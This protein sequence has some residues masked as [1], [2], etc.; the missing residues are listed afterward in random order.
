VARDR[1]AHASPVTV[2]T[3]A[4]PGTY[5][6]ECGKPATVVAVKTSDTESGIY[7][8]GRCK[9]HAHAP[10]HDNAGIIRLEPINGQVNMLLPC[11]WQRPE[12]VA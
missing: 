8:A 11:G 9:D 3:Y 7:Y 1:V 4:P 2:C 5:G 12:S 10:G 6:H